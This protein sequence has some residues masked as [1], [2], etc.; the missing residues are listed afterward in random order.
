M[1]ILDKLVK[2]LDEN[3]VELK[4]ALAYKE[5]LGMI[6]QWE[7][8]PEDRLKFKKKRFCID[9]P[10]A[11]LRRILFYMDDSL[12]NDIIEF[13]S[14]KRSREEKYNDSLDYALKLEKIWNI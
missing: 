7:L 3:Y 6:D 13:K 2:F 11:R 8:K 12:K 10:Q 9:G 4:K 5:Y 14:D 1:D